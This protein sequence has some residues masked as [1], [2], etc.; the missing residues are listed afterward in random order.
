[1]LL[2]VLKTVLVSVEDELIC[3]WSLW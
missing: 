3:A 2:I 1:M